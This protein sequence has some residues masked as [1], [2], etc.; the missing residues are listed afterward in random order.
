MGCD[1][2]TDLAFRYRSNDPRRGLSHGS[3][4][5]N[6]RGANRVRREQGASRVT[7][8]LFRKVKSSSAVTSVVD[9]TRRGS[10]RQAPC[11]GRR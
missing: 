7:S 4:G 5:A 2:A 1:P 9:R 6:G 10:Q 3:G 11:S 8:F